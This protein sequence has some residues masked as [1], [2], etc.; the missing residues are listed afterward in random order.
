S[1]VMVHHE[2]KSY[3]SQFKVYQEVVEFGAVLDD[4]MIA[5]TNIRRA[6]DVALKFMRPV[7]LEVPRD[8]VFAE[9]PIPS[10]FEDVELKVDR[11]AVEEAAQEIV[12]RLVA[13]RHP[14]IVVGVEVRRFRLQE[15]VLRLAEKLQVPVTSSFL[16]RGVFPTLHSQFIGTYLGTVSPKPL[17]Q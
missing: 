3:E 4:P 9:I 16:G 10:G 12:E 13:S 17:R 11:G 15:K 8:M 14:V 5:A 2:V 6:I 1:G 7:Y